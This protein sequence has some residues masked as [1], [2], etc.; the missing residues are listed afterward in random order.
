MPKRTINLHYDNDPDE[1]SAL[2]NRIESMENNYT[3]EDFMKYDKTRDIL[4]QNYIWE[5][6]KVCEETLNHFYESEVD[7]CKADL[8]TLFNN[9]SNHENCGAFR[10]IVFKHVRPKYDLNLIYYDE[11]LCKT[12]IQYHEEHIKDKEMERLKKQRENYSKMDN[13]GKTF[14]WGTKSYK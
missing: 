9:E 12:F 11:K 5:F 1:D 2:Q 14:A 7:F 3:L 10:A 13:S 4:E 8:S 6:E